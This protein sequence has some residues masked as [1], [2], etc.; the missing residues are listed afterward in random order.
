MIGFET[1]DDCA[2]YRLNDETAVIQTVDFFPPVVDDPF[3]F[4]QIAAANALSDLYAMGAAPSLAMNLICFPS[5]LPLDVIR[6]ILE[7]GYQKTAEAGA[8]IAGGHTIEDN[9]PKYG[10]CVTGFAHPQQ[11]LAN[12]TAKEGDILILTKGIG[13]GILSTAAKASLLSEQQYEQMIAAMTRLNKYAWEAMTPCRPNACTDITGFGL[14]GHAYEMASGSGKTLEIFE[15]EVPLLDGVTALAME[16]IIPAGAYRNRDYLAPYVE[17]GENIPE[18]TADALFDPQTSG[19]LLI[20]VPESKVSELL[21]R[22][23]SNAE[24]G[25]VVGRV[26]PYDGISIRVR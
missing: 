1:S 2:V 20:S 5:C 7:G 19:G 16:G 9:E 8:I 4:G 18:A 11:I 22:L 13:T 3:T 14:L 25:T 26:L 10:L 17:L 15:A 21:D 6:A 12:S 23:E 24:T